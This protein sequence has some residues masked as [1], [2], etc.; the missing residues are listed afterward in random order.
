MNKNQ[1][2]KLRMLIGVSA[3]LRE[4]AA[5]IAN[6]PEMLAAQNKL[7]EN[8][9]KI[10]EKFN[11]TNTALFGKTED[12][13]SAQKET[14]KYI[15]ALSGALYAYSKKVGDNEL[16][17]EAAITRTYLLGLREVELFPVV[18]NLIKKARTVSTQLNEFGINPDII[19]VIED[20]LQKYNEALGKR[21]ISTSEKTTATKS[22]KELFTES[23]GNLAL[24]DKFAQVLKLNYAQF[25]DEYR[26]VRK[27]KNIGESVIK[28][29]LQK[30]DPIDPIQK[31]S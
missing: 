22:V 30:R 2:N 5:T 18:E 9:R 16:S 6:I 27:I 4:N 1:D 13:F 24:L 19:N 12:K 29:K 8:I 31:A 10:N 11:V 3:F 20:Y 7:D 28:E 26:N 14:I 23:N 25:Y 15:L 21:E 17:E